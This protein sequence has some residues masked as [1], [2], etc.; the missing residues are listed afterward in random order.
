MTDAFSNEWI[1]QNINDP[2]NELVVLRKVIPWQGIIN[3]LAH[4]YNHKSGRIGTS[5]R[6]VIAVFIVAKLRSL[7]DRFVIAQIRENRYM[8][9]FCNVPDQDLANFM[10]PSNLSKLRKRF[11]VK[12]IKAI[13]STT[14]DF[15]R[16]AGVIKG[17]NMLIDSTVLSNNIDYVW[18]VTTRVG[19]LFFLS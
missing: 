2:T 18:L 9:Y 19:G 7:S 10:N 12:G 6:M 11:G 1:E 14:F 15:L 16:L 17:D 13:E 8:Q 5:L 3:K 4:Y